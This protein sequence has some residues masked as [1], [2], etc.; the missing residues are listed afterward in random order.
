MSNLTRACVTGCDAKFTVGAATLLR[1]VKRFHPDVARYCFTPPSD[2]DAVAGQLGDLAVVLP[3]PKSIRIVPQ[4]MQPALLKL[5]TPLVPAD[6]AAWLDCDMIMCRPAP[7]IWEC[8]PGEVVAVRDTA[9]DVSCMVEERLKDLYQKQFPDTFRHPGF[10]GGF[11]TL[12]TAEWKSLPE[13]YEDS[14]EKGGYPHHPK[15]W[16]QPFL[17][18]L[19]QPKVRYLPYAFNAHHVFDFSIPSDVRIVHFTNVPKP[20]MPNYPKHEPAYYYW[21]RYGMREERKWELFKTELRILLR[22][23]RR[24]FARWAKPKI[25]SMTS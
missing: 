4:S 12:R 21:L 16:D 2:V 24:L 22:T 23:P 18:G 11:F 1:D 19:M 9:L 5:F 15:I 8:R 25:R 3:A 20:W 17:N 6:V 14:F 10:N 13:I 7:E